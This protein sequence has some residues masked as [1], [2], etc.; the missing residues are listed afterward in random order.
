MGNETL[1]GVAIII[2][3]LVPPG[4]AVFRHPGRGM[5]LTERFLLGAA[6][7]PFALALPAFALALFVRLPVDWAM[8]QSEFIWIV[9]ALWPRWQPKEGAP[10]P[11]PE[12]LPEPG[13]GFPSIAALATAVPVALLVAGVA[14]AVPMVRMWSDAWFH[15]GA[16]IEIFRS[17]VPPQDPNFAGVP[18]YYP[19]AYHFILAVLGGAGRISPFH[20]MALMNGWAALVLALSAAQLAYRAFGRGAAT[21][22]G[23]IAVLG[24]NPLGWL[25]WILHGAIGET[26]GLGP[27]IAQISTTNGV[28]TGLTHIFPPWH[29]TMLNRFWTGTA[30][31]PAIALGLA[32]AWSAARALD[33]PTRGAWLRTL[34]LLLATVATHPA[35][36][37]FAA[38][39]IGVGV[40]AAAVAPGRR[41]AALALMGALAL[42]GVA[43]LAWIRACG[44]PG[45]TTAVHLGIYTRNLW[46]LLLAIGPWWLVAAPGLVAAWRAGPSARF[47]LG[48]ASAAVAIAIA[49]VL[50]EANS[51][52]FLYL[53]WVS[54]APIAAAGGVAWCDR[55]RLPGIARLTLLTAL[56]LPTSSLYAIGNASDRRSPGVLIRGDTPAARQLPLATGPENGVY[57]YIR[58]STPLEAVVIEQPRPT[59]NEPV[60]VLG[61]RRVF[62][63][64]LDV[65]IS[66]HFHGGGRA[67]GDVPALMDEF[68]VRRGIQLALFS[69]GLLT[70]SQSLYL[71]HFA[72]PLYLLVRRSEVPDPIWQGFRGRAEWDEL[73]ANEQVRFYR[74]TR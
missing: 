64:S 11:A 35:Y 25:Y 41:G 30:L 47:T 67:T 28:A 36:A 72:M 43:C 52:K 19:W 74:Y 2:L 66:N 39:A 70:P 17:G 12:P 71:E 50:P 57:R 9:A 63:G 45:A 40:A 21:C 4:V 48:A 44:V 51:D 61:E 54:L 32:A 38:V 37:A 24:L 31:T 58:Q 65:Y 13:H 10:A 20:T 15:A 7:A 8:W 26:R 42:A 59:V 23:V 18:L 27:M 73:I 29:S 14:L 56:V 1:R 5:R 3:A 33:R 22:A 34:L 68:E 46:S 6:L 16:T 53:A 69:E 55:L 60:P 49:V 62:C